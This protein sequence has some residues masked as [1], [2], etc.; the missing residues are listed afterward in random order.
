MQTQTTTCLDCNREFTPRKYD[1]R[2]R[3]VPCL[4]R[5]DM[6]ASQMRRY[7]R[8]RADERWERA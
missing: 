3:C 1:D 4:D 2:L 7:E 8:D 6:Y 5:R